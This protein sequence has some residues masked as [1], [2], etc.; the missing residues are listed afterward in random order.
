MASPHA[1][2][3]LALLASR[4]KPNNA[5]DVYNLYNQVKSAGNFDWTDDSGDGIKEP[6]LDVST[7]L[8]TLI[9]VGAAN[10]PPNVTITSPAEGVTF[11]EGAAI[12]FAGTAIDTENGT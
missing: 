4:N 3:A 8:P 11:V 2:G 1:A 5:T 10:S 12:S 6:L 9:A 7:F